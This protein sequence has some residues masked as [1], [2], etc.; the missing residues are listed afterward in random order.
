MKKNNKADC[1][2][3]TIWLTK[4][5]LGWLKSEQERLSK[6]GWNMAIRGDGFGRI[7]LW[8]T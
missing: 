4:A 7:A 5:D 2:Q 3:I 6:K 1:Q 8:R